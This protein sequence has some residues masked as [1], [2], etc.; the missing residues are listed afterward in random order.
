MVTSSLMHPS[1]L[2]FLLPPPLLSLV[3]NSKITDADLRRPT[4][5]KSSPILKRP[6]AASPPPPLDTVHSSLA[7]LHQ[8]ES[9]E[10]GLGP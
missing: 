5:N 6:S 2:I 9:L 3:L 8:Q 1:I 10:L 4:R 7:C